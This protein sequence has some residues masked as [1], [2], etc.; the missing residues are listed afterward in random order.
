VARR[1][2]L[3]V[4]S[5]VLAQ[6][7]NYGRRRRTCRCRSKSATLVTVQLIPFALRQFSVTN[8][9]LGHSLHF[10]D[11]RVE[12]ASLRILLQKSKVAGLRI[13]RENTKREAIAD[14]FNRVTEVACEFDVRRRGPITGL[15]Y[16]PMG[17]LAPSP[18]A[19]SAA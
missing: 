9:D 3:A 16:S 4:S 5:A 8:A 14:S 19:V 11:V 1:S 15:D 7:T 18:V 2:R 13:F 10:C 12:S 6:A 17:H